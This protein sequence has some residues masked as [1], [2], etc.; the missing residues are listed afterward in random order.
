MR[1]LAV[2]AACL[3]LL[4]SCS[5]D[6]GGEATPKETGSTP[7]SATATST[8]VVERPHGAAADLSEELPGE[9]AFLADVVAEVELPDGWTE[10][11][12]VAAGTAQA[13]G[14][15]DAEYRTRVAV[16]YPAAEDFNGTVV[17]E[18]LNVSSGIDANPDYLMAYEEIFREGYAWVGVS[19][20]QIGVEGGDVAVPVD[21][22][23]D[24]A[25]KGLKGIDPERYGSLE[26]PG[27]AYA[28]DMYTQIGRALRANE[29]ALGEL[30][31]ERLLADGESQSAFALTTY[32][33]EIQ[34]ETRA[35]DGFLIHSRGVSGLGSGEPGEALDIAGAISKEPETIRT[36]L[37]APVM[38]VESETDLFSV[39]NYL[40][41]RQDDTDSIR[42][43]EIAGTAHAD[44]KVLGPAADSIDCGVP[45]NDGPQHFVVK[46]ALRSLDTW[47][48]TGEAPPEAP[49][50]S[51]DRDEDGIILDGIR[52]P[53]VDVPA[54]VLSG[55]PGPNADIICLL[56][57]STKPLGKDRLAEL[58][59]SPEDYL[60][61][62]E[63]ATDAAIEAGFVLEADRQAMLDDAKPDLI[64]G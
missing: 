14:A 21:V 61:Q 29:G 13:E 26:H 22:A 3:L 42:V 4:A 62:Y 48:R 58:Y 33:N 24:L 54:R 17:A 35:F 40:P 18:W 64:A 56:L 30:E 60:A 20:Q 37:D 55:A 38:I 49:R 16:R 19:A 1:S 28:Y 8:T 12:F 15:P 53:Q 11:E 45:I 27:D 36:D 51:E 10:R 50:L 5:S 2:G 31:P 43:W 25:G 44:T 57:G 6:S 23:G 7:T 39:I 32:A 47:V 59:D 46:A 9:G 52:T 41:A 34:P 63:A